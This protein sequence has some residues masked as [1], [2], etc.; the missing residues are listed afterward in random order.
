[1]AKYVSKKRK[2]P[3]SHRA[4]AWEAAKGVAVK[5]GPRL[6]KNMYKKY[7]QKKRPQKPNIAIG[8]YLGPVPKLTNAAMPKTGVNKFHFEDFGKNSSGSFSGG[9]TQ[10]GCAYIGFADSG[11]FAVYLAAAGAIV[12][13]ALAR[14]S[15]DAPS[16]W[17]GT[18]DPGLGNM[19]L[20]AR[21]YNHGEGIVYDDTAY[22]ISLGGQSLAWVVK[23]FAQ[24]LFDMAKLGK[25]LY[26]LDINPGTT[27]NVMYRCDTIADSILD[28]RIRTNVK[29]QNVT[30][31]DSDPDASGVDY[32]K[33]AINANPL[34]GMI[35]RFADPA[36]K[37]TE[38]VV[39]EI[40]SGERELEQ[41]MVNYTDP[42][43]SAGRL[44][45]RALYSAN[46]NALTKY[47]QPTT[48]PKTLWSN[49]THSAKVHLQPGGYRN[50]AF[51]FNY[52]GTVTRFLENIAV[53]QLVVGSTSSSYRSMPKL[54]AS[55]LI[56][57]EPA[58]R[59]NTN[60]AVDVAWNRE[61]D[62]K[63]SFKFYRKP[64]LPV[65]NIVLDTGMTMQD[66]WN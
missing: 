53:K 27:G 62:I 36:P 44:Y 66:A 26:R 24:V 45:C 64:M 55:Y 5:H 34:S 49:C 31:A 21:S 6:I 15:V 48:K 56:G 11:G 40:S 54:G 12:R 1:M 50:L 17:P 46:N 41:T 30:A 63:S 2:K 52:H 16:T 47:A 18:L 60:E 35:Y 59:T 38:G 19:D 29:F 8:P 13:S 10:G 20:Y 65:R 25:V 32:N 39:T 51:V 9:S 4:K 22:P 14:A 23:A 58:L 28:I 61:I 57:L 33:N 42:S 43:G 7:S 37:F 3:T